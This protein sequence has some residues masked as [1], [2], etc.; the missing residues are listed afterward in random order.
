MPFEVCHNYLNLLFD[1]HGEGLEDINI[2]T[3]QINLNFNLD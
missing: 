3:T 2:V 1:R